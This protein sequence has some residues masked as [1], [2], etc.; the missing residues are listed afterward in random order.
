MIEKGSMCRLD[1]GVLRGVLK[2]ELRV[3]GANACKSGQHRGPTNTRCV[4]RQTEIGA[5]GAGLG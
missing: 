2:T 3:F 4:E 5:G 1:K